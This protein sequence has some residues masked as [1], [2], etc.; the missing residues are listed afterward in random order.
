M[1]EFWHYPSWKKYYI[2][3][4]YFFIYFQDVTSFSSLF[5]CTKL[6]KYFFFLSMPLDLKVLSLTKNSLLPFLYQRSLIFLSLCSNLFLLNLDQFFDFLAWG[7]NFYVELI[8]WHQSILVLT[9]WD[10]LSIQHE[11]LSIGIPIKY[12]V[13]ILCP[14][15]GSP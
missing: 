14:G 1:K 10:C 2:F 8:Y 6:T 7:N 15:T 3:P 11:K 9:L 5:Y 12:V 4:F 13:W